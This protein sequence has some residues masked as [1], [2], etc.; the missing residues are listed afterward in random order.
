[1][2]PFSFPLIGINLNKVS[3]KNL[4]NSPCSFQT[5]IEKAYELRVVVLF[6]KVFPCKIYSQNSELA[7]TDW[8]V[9]DDS[10]VK[11]ELSVIPKEIELKLIKMR[12]LLDLSWCSVDM[13]YGKDKKYYFLE[14]NRPGAHYWL[15][16]FVGLDITKEIVDEIK[17]YVS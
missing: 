10:N 3:L 17:K 8:R 7:K 6:D 16:Y 12:E 13:I 4:K 5:Y 9:Y 1:V 2:S 11:W 14:A 15:D